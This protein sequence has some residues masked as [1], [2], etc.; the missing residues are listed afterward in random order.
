MNNSI[1]ECLNKSHYYKNFEPNFKK[2]LIITKNYCIL[3]S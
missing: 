3:A 1:S 2:K